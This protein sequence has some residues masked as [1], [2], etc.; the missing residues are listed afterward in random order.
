[1]LGGAV[2]L[3]GACLFSSRVSSLWSLYLMTGVLAAIGACAVSWV[4]SGALSPGSAARSTTSPA[5]I[6]RRF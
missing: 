2:V 1:M 5:A 4:P 6:A 3:G